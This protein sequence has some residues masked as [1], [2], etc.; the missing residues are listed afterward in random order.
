MDA[1]LA[2]VYVREEST[3]DQAKYERINEARVPLPARLRCRPSKREAPTALQHP[4]FGKVQPGGWGSVVSKA[5]E[6]L[7]S[8]FR[9]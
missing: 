5:W 1:L 3:P 8:N 7:L 9:R 2:H 4:E 6:L